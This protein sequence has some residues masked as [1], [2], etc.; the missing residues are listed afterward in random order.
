[1]LGMPGGFV[2]PDEGAEVALRREIREEVG[3]SVGHL[4]FLMTAP[5]SYSYHGIVHPVLDIFF[6]A[7]VAE[8]QEIAQDV[9]EVS[10]WMWTE[11]TP[12]ILARIAFPSNRHALERFL[13]NRQKSTNRS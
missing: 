11:L 2:D 7:S 5:N 13:V 10:A 6:C 4:T 3:I 12:E 9:S 8:D 1:M